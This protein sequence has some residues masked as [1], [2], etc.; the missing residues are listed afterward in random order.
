MTSSL[1]IK[2]CCIPDNIFEK[3]RHLF[4][5]LGV[6]NTTMDD[7]AK[8]LGISKKTLYQQIKNKADLIKFCVKYELQKDVDLIETI[9]ENTENA[10]EELLIIAEHINEKLQHFNP[11]MMRELSK[12]Y[13]ESNE[14]IEQHLENFAK[15]NIRN[16][17]KKG[18]KQGLY[19][20]DINI[21]MTIFIQQH[22]TFLPLN[23]KQEMGLN[24]SQ[25]YQE[26]IRYNLYAI[27]TPKGISLFEKLRNKKN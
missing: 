27:A 12:F 19:R 17:L 25:I 23:D 5:Q 8:E 4:F 2:D 13:P 11:V 16:N 24:P 10:I 15:N 21:E 6:R 14:L 1:Q 3:A 9:S 20:P 18:I 22:L 26:I 7:L